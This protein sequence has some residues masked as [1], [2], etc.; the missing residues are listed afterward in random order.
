[1]VILTV[2]AISD[3]GLDVI[4]NIRFVR[5]CRSDVLEHII[6]DTNFFEKFILFCQASIEHRMSS[7]IQ[8]KVKIY[9]FIYLLVFYRSETS[10]IEM[11]RI[12][13]GIKPGNTEKK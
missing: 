10:E 2:D 3:T 13:S 12:S 8:I 11:A 7:L 9:L 6:L 4:D 5:G 1:M